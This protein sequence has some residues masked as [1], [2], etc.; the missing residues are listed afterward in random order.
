MF[1][2]KTI[3]MISA[4]GGTQKGVIN[5]EYKNGA[6]FGSVR[7]YNCSQL[8]GILVLAFLD[9][10]KVIK[11]GL[12]PNSSNEWTFKTE[13]KVNLEK[14]FVSV[15]QVKNSKP[16]P[17]VVGSFENGKLDNI[18]SRLTNCISTVLDSPKPTI[19]EVE[20]VLDNNNI[21]LDEEENIAIEEALDKEFKCSNNCA[22]CSYREAFYKEQ[23]A[24]PPAQV[25]YFSQVSEQIKKLFETNQTDSQ[26]EEIIP[27]SKWVKVDYEQDGNYYVV[28]LIYS[29]DGEQLDYVCYG[30]PGFYANNAPKE[31]EGICKWVPL[32][33]S[34]PL[35]M[36]YWIT[37]QNAQ[38][39][40]NVDVEII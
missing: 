9:N 7:L 31:L 3:I 36:G 29:P 12:I 34:R 19:K 35:E 40:E 10:S 8:D 18:R 1:F 33:S 37:Y 15:V 22:K 14:A 27:N 25:S 39:G 6:T 32:D 5:A 20:E 13:E 21:E 11:C 17:I 23:V 30:L 38:T 24:P 16:T 4:S 28:G 26:L 2:K